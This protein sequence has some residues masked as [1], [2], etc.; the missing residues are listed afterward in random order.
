MFEKVEDAIFV[1]V[2]DANSTD[3]ACFGS[4]VCR[5]HY[6][7]FY[8][9]KKTHGAYH[10]PCIAFYYRLQFLHYKGSTVGKV[11]AQLSVAVGGVV[12]VVIHPVEA[13]K[14]GVI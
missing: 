9:N 11:N 2:N 7:T 12:Q 5:R 8:H 1:P 13:S 14:R 3:H 4:L 10:G 6:T